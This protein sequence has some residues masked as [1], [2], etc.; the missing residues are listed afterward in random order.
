[1]ILLKIKPLS[2]NK[3]WQGRRF[4]TKE[5]EKYEKDVL[6]L[7]PKLKI[8]TESKLRLDI[9]VGFS[10]TRSDLDNICK[11]IIDIM[12]KKYGFNDCNIYELHITKAIVRKGEDYIKI[13]I[14]QLKD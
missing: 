8:D 6:L 4:K 11:P 14:N 7:L 1:M 10:S 2:V 13:T 5:Y 12:Q 3:C 9:E